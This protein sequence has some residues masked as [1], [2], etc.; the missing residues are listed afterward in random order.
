MKKIFIAFAFIAFGTVVVAQ[1]TEKPMK[2][3]S[4][5]L[6]AAPAKPATTTQTQ[7]EQKPATKPTAV[8][9]TKPIEERNK[10]PQK[11]RKVESSFVVPSESNNRQ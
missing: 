7:A 5:E 10:K 6:K 1:Q 8:T 4:K 3:E 9:Q 2:L 11:V